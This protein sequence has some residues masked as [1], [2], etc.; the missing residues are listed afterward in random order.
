MAQG[1]LF[2]T[3][4]KKQECTFITGIKQ[5]SVAYHLSSYF[6]HQNLD[7]KISKT[8]FTVHTDVYKNENDLQPQ[9]QK[10]LC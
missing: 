7:L 3:S 8:E 5:N 2:L 10:L 6:S 9:N 4:H 1:I